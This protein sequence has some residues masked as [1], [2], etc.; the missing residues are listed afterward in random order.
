MNAKFQWFGFSIAR[1]HVYFYALLAATTLAA[2]S[3]KYS[4]IGP[5]DVDLAQ[6]T[7]LEET[8]AEATIAPLP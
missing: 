3:V 2:N 4:L 1:K 7:Q 8:V 6:L 5:T